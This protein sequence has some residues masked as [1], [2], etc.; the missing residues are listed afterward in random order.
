MKNLIKVLL[1]AC[2]FV[3][4]S[5]RLL[6]QNQAD[7]NG[8]YLSLQDYQQNKLSYSLSKHD[9]LYLHEFLEG[10]NLML[11]YEGK[12]VKLPKNSIFGY[13]WHGQNYRLYHNISYRILDTAGFIL[14]TREKLSPANKGFKE[15]PAYAYSLDLKQQP[16]N[17][18]MENLDST[19]LSETGFRY[20][21]QCNFKTDEELSA[22]DVFSHQYKIKYL[23]YKF[24]N[25]DTQS[26]YT[27]VKP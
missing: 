25:K 6:A 22:F 4:P 17:L 18:T 14:Y 5:K 3:L 13:Q 10:K 26:V 8:V 1:A 12:K 16:S 15:M 20:A 7:S 27:V 19:F 2:C 24:K 21:L 9:K 23:Y 11:R